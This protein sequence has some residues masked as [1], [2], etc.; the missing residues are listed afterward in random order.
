MKR[1]L[2]FLILGVILSSFLFTAD[3]GNTSTVFFVKQADKGVLVK[4]A[5]KDFLPVEK[6]EPTGCR[7]PLS[8]V[9]YMPPQTKAVFVYGGK[10]HLFD[11]QK[12]ARKIEGTK[13]VRFLQAKEINKSSS[14]T[15]KLRRVYSKFFSA[16]IFIV[17]MLSLVG[18]G[19]MCIV[20]RGNILLYFG[21]FSLVNILSSV[22]SILLTLIMQGALFSG[23]FNLDSRASIQMGIIFVIL[24]IIAFIGSSVLLPREISHSSNTPSSDISEDGLRFVDVEDLS[25]EERKKLSI[26]LGDSD[27]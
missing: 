5:G 12:N 8:S 7:F 20:K 9:I 3:M 23:T 14:C 27:L 25:E 19:F 21:I 22:I 13:F 6:F 18:Y 1:T 11:K 2:L 15:I 24:N 16:A 10:T 26:N 17:F 4:L